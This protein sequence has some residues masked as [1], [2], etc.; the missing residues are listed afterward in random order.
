VARG[1]VVVFTFELAAL[2]DW[3]REYLREGLE[4][5]QPRFPPV[6]K[7][8]ELLGGRSRIE[9]IATPADCADGFFEAFW[10]RPEQLLDPR[11]RASQSMWALLRSG[12]EQRIVDRLRTALESGAWDQSHG[13]LR[14]LDE[15]DGALRLVVS[16]D[17]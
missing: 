12:V 16:D 2:P 9:H 5:E 4:V 3:Q 6:E 10:N 7:V 15:F 1:P 17:G 13:H 11:V 14:Q 8:A